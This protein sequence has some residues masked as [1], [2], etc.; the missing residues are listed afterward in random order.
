M[1]KLERLALPE[2]YG[3][4]TETLPWAT[5]SEWLTTAK[6]YWVAINRPGSSPH[7]VP[8]DGIW[9]EDTL[10]YGGGQATAHVR[11]AEADPNVTVHLPDPWK[12]VVVHGE[13]RK[14]K[15]TRELSQ[16]LAD[17]ANAKY[18][19]YGITYD[20]NS[21]A[22][23]FALHPHRVIAWSSFPRDATRYVFED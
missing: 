13:A 1:P 3:R 19:E 11:L 2:E 12:V 15:P 21:F 7:V 6:Q 4:T 8:V 14:A 16:H 23:P 10:W 18:T 20:A 9:T 22:D 17:L 5:V